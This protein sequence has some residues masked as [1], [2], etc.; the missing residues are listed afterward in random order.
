MNDAPK[1]LTEIMNKNSNDNRT[2]LTLFLKIPL[3]ISLLTIPL[4][5]LK[6]TSVIQWSWW[7]VLCPLWL[8][9]FV[10][11]FIIGLYVLFVWRS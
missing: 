9:L 11:G 8:I 10:C 7:M 1:W 6:L 4:S 2:G 3:M 5:I